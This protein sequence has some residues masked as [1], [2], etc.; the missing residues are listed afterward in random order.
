MLRKEASSIGSGS[1][2]NMKRTI[3]PAIPSTYQEKPIEFTPEDISR[4]IEQLVTKGPKY[5]QIK[6]GMSQ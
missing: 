5:N 1:G 6:K 3:L 2:N 4:I